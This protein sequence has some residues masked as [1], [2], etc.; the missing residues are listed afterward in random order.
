[1]GPSPSSSGSSF[2]MGEEWLGN[3]AIRG[4]RR[5]APDTRK[6]SLHECP[7][8]ALVILRA[9]KDP[10]YKA[11][12]GRMLDQALTRPDD[13]AL[14]NLDPTPAVAGTA[15]LASGAPRLAHQV[16]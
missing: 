15:S 12:L 11:D 9:Q 8:G 4:H 16:G 3:E 1:M 10:A 2:M 6:H 5:P 13:R 14:F 7:V